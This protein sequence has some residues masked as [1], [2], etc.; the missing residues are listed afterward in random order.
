M[1]GHSH[2]YF[3]AEINSTEVLLNI[4][5]ASLQCQLIWLL[6]AFQID[7]HHYTF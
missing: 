7:A 6:L 3:I 2:V 4:Y 5:V 1:H